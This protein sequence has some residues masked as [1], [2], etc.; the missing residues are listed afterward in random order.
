MD[1]IDDAYNGLMGEEFMRKTRERLH[2]MC[3]KVDGVK[4]LDIGCSQ[5]T[6]DRILGSLGKNILG[7]DINKEAI[8][9]AEGKLAE[10]DAS[11]RERVRF[12]SA[13][14]MDFKT[15]ERFETVIIGEVLEHLAFPEAFVKKAHGHLV[16]NGVIVVT[17]PFGINDD[18]D[19]R[20]TFYWSWIN[21]I[22]APYFD[23]KEVKFF[24]KW[25][26]VVGVK[27]D[28]KVSFEKSVPFD[29]VKEL[30]KAFYAI[31]RPIV[32]DN[33]I[34]TE[35]MKA[36]QKT[37]DDTKASLSAAKCEAIKAVESETVQRTRADKAAA[38]Y[39]KLKTELTAEIAK[40]K[41]ALSKASGEKTIAVESAAK[42]KTILEG[43]VARQKTAL[44]AEQAKTKDL[45]SKVVA[46]RNELTTLKKRSG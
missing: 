29:V 15:E 16:K 5:G 27:R 4:I 30:E 24:G 41:E 21:E 25:I 9:F 22:I 19:H 23:I 44:A 37:L 12:S 26:G 6:L 46:L 38:D 31:E 1:R 20:Q 43:E 39:A 8:A 28:K 2:W 17:V 40:Q 11:T 13:N 7:V 3:S 35:K 18:P 36:Q 14:F 32:N 33:K 42:Q 45:N 10:M 34:R